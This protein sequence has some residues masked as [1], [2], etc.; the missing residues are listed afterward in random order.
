MEPDDDSGHFGGN[1]ATTSGRLCQDPVQ[2]K[3]LSVQSVRVEKKIHSHKADAKNAAQS[4]FRSS[5][6]MQ[7]PN[8]GEGNDE[9]NHIQAQ[10][11]DARDT[12]V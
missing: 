3:T 7:L 2:K 4:Y 11:D 6:N 1:R 5:W 8:D 12:E 9:E 10:V